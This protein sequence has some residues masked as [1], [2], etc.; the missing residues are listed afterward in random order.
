MRSPSFMLTVLAS[1]LWLCGIGGS[2]VLGCA[3]TG[4]PQSLPAQP[5]DERAE[6]RDAF[7]ARRLLLDARKLRAQGRLES[8]E[9]VCARGLALD[10]DSSGLHQ[11]RGELL[12]ELGR[13]DEARTY[14]QRARVLAPPPAPLSQSPADLVS[15]DLVVML[16][17]PTSRPS[18]SEE[19]QDWALDPVTVV[20][21]R[22]LRTR[23]PDATVQLS[24]SEDQATHLSVEDGRAWLRDQGARAAVTLRVERAFCGTSIKDG[25]FS[26][27]RLRVASAAPEPQPPARVEV[28]KVG[29]DL[30]RSDSCRETAAA[31]ALELALENQEIHG[32]LSTKAVADPHWSAESIRSLFPALDAAIAEELSAG[33]RLAR[34]GQLDLAIGHFRR[35][36]EIDS[37]DHDARTLL[38]DTKRSLALSHQISKASE[39]RATRRGLGESADAGP[40][41]RGGGGAADLGSGLTDHQR[42][43]LEERLREEHAR[44]EL[45]L[46]ALEMVETDDQPPTRETIAAMRPAELSDPESRGGRLARDR[47][48]API[49]ARALYAPDGSLLARYYFA[50]LASHGGDPGPESLLVREEDTHGTG[51]ADRWVVFDSGVRSEVWELGADDQ[52]EFRMVYASAGNP[53]ERIEIDAD[54][55]GLS[56]RI[57]YYRDG[58]VRSESRDTSGDGFF[59]LVEHFDAEGTLVSREEDRSHDGQTDIRTTYENG[60]II[61]REILNA[62]FA[63]EL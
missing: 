24:H 23:L 12:E 41:V 50:A 60:R 45:L 46:A 5:A 39:A 28:K 59:D 14:Q 48:E 13:G 38:E 35:A 43:V 55:N 57:F 31:R 49:Q 15:A 8:A 9:H 11:L 51:H 62:E 1:G 6:E 22:R 34:A 42:R 3:G 36:L 16:L 2:G 32:P 56:E 25:R 30:A 10:P 47:S 27:A 18:L 58:A 33:R 40:D 20:L 63:G 21:E 29:S 7:Y 4:Q 17:P 26:I 37:E 54:G 53:L 61:R 44:R 52:A 19:Q